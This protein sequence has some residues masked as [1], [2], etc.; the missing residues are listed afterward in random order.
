MQRLKWIAEQEGFKV[1]EEALEL[2]ARQANGSM[3]DSDSLLDQ[4]AAG[5]AREVTLAQVQA[6]LGSVSPQ[7][8]SSL[9][10]KIASQNLAEGL[11][12][13]DGAVRE[14]ADPRQLARQVIEY[15]RGVLLLKVTGQDPPQVTPEV[16]Q[17]MARLGQG[18][19]L[20]QLS[21]VIRNF[22]RA[23]WDF[24]ASLPPELPLE[25]AFV[26]SVLSEGQELPVAETPPPKKKPAAASRGSTPQSPA[27]N[28]PPPPSRRNNPPA[29]ASTDGEWDVGS[30]EL[31]KSRW[32]EFMG[33][34]RTKNLHVEALL[35]SGE[36]LGVRRDKV[37]LGFYY[38]FHKGQ[39]ENA[40]NREV[41]VDALQQ[42]MGRAVGVQ[43]VLIQEV[44]ERKASPASEDPVIRLARE[45]GAEVAPLSS[46]VGKEEDGDT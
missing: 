9:V 42:I 32:E 17:E 40:R 35:K 45:M 11:Q 36:P 28:Q 41:V 23:S 31:L 4:V 12:I 26:D 22:Q 19:S 5:G 29:A 16:G 44:A 30:F 3:R 33:L 21:T 15:L 7:A 24:K 38:P 6:I 39:I 37:V 8:V 2:I 14:G 43:C 18:I 13:I 20:E 25:L 27:K 34:I 46:G 10:E 1:E